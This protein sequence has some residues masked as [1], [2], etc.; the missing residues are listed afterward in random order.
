MR[1]KSKLAVFVAVILFVAAGC[2]RY[3]SQ[4][5]NSLGTTGTGTAIAAVT[6]DCTAAACPELTVLG[7]SLATLPNGS[8]SSFRGFADPTM[9]KDPTSN[10]LWMAYSWPHLNV[11]AGSKKPIAG[12]ETHLAYSNDNGVTW[13]YQGQL[14]PSNAMID[15]GN[16][17]G[18]GFMEHEVPNL[19]PVDRNGTVTWYGVRL[20]Y[21][22]PNNGGYASRPPQSFQLKIMQASTPAG[23]A[24]ASGQVLGSMATAKGWGANVN[25]AALSS[26]TSDCELWNEPAL[27]YQNNLLYLSTR[28]L[29]YRGRQ[30]DEADSDFE[31][32]S[33]AAQGSISNWQWKY[34]G[35]LTNASIASQLGHI[36]TTQ[37]DLANGT[38]GK[39][40][41][42]LSPED[43]N[44]SIKDYVHYGCVALE[45]ASIDPP[46]LA[47]NSSG[48]LIVRAQITASDEGTSG[49]A[50]CTYEPSSKTGI[51]LVRRQKTSTEFTTSLNETKVRP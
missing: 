34:V 13:K 16:N 39:L 21:F 23:L 18:A 35:N 27:Y 7:D 4:N 37:L 14:W 11:V 12:V 22:V 32:Y 40:L 8:L 19:L 44:P 1:Q 43:Y 25:L 6:F 50:A 41:A 47:H 26:K 36:G 48:N 28:C 9:R 17:T 15:L 20:D 24:N 33:T 10:T 3:I 29:A 2:N 45:V 30:M 51:V 5:S 46:S 38:D 42:I 49:S 31:I